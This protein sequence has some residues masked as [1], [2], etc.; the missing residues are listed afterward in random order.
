M[1]NLSFQQN[2]EAPVQKPTRA[3]RAAK[4]SFRSLSPKNQRDVWTGMIRC[5]AMYVAELTGR[6]KNKWQ[7]AEKLQYKVTRHIPGAWKG[8]SQEKLRTILSLPSIEDRQQEMAGMLLTRTIQR[9]GPLRKAILRATPTTYKKKG[10]PWRTGRMGKT[11]IPAAIIEAEGLWPS[12]R[13]QVTWGSPSKGDSGRR[14]TQLQLVE[15]KNPP[16]KRDDWESAIWMAEAESWQTIYTDGSRLEVEVRTSESEPIKGWKLAPADKERRSGWGMYSSKTRLAGHIGKHCSVL[17]AE[18]R[19]I[20]AALAVPLE[21]SDMRLILT[22]L[23]AAIAVVESLANGRRA[24]ANAWQR[25]LASYFPCNQDKT[26]AIAWVKAH[27]GVD[28]NKGADRE[29][30][31]GATNSHQPEVISADEIR[32][33]TNARKKLNRGTWNTYKWGKRSLRPFT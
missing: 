30:K 23:Q 31:R 16:A 2:I 18:L 3:W 1:S 17:N 15:E 6:D 13:S 11:P 26:L 5:M 7:V 24:P 27:M 32:E 9:S 14:F 10:E 25:G 4:S 12:E 33:V 22:D 19:A 21:Q 28:G 8:S 20:T 29:A